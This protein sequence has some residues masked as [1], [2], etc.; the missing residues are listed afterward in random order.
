MAPKPKRP[1]SVWIAQIILGIYGFGLTSIV[2]WGLY[3]G[4]TEGIQYPEAYL[5]TTVGS[6]TFIAVFVGGVWGMALRRPW[7]RW[8]GVA[9]LM[10]L[11]IAAAITQTSRWVSD[12]EISFV[13]IGFLYSVIVVVGI[14]FLVYFIAA[15]DAADNFFNGKSS[16]VQKASGEDSDS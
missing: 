10:I 8:L 2:V 11:L 3:K 12:K 4:I 14:A 6:L 13:S 7:G 5:M 15:G 1:I 9:G 16:K